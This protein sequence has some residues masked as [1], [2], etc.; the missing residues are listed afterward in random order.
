MSKRVLPDKGCKKYAN[1]EEILRDPWHM[2]IQGSSESTRDRAHWGYLIS[3]CFKRGI[4][5][6][7]HCPRTRSRQIAR[8]T[9]MAYIELYEGVHTA[10]RPY[11]DISGPLRYFIGLGAG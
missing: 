9:K 2:Q 6:Y 7:S 8:P 11:R 4:M 1:M 10:Q 3:L 5:V